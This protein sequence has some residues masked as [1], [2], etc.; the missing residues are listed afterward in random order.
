MDGG[1]RL[2]LAPHRRPELMRGA[3]LL[4]LRET[5][6]AFWLEASLRKHCFRHGQQP[7]NRLG[8]K[9][10]RSRGGEQILP[11]EDTGVWRGIAFAR[12]RG[13]FGRRPRP[14]MAPLRRFP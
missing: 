2:S 11:R 1:G 9:A 4:S 6:I 13:A 5:T 10:R 7:Q 12:A 8:G 14:K 3:I